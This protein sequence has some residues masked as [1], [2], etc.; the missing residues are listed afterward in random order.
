MLPTPS[1]SH[2]NTDQIYEPAEDSFLILDTLSSVGEI[3]FLSERFSDQHVTT[4][5]SPL[6]LEVGTGSGVVLAFL[7]AHAEAIFGRPDILTLGSDINHFACQ[8]SKRTVSQACVEAKTV[9]TKSQKRCYTGTMLATMSADLTGPFRAGVIDVLVFNPPYVPS[10]KVPLSWQQSD[11]IEV[12]NLPQKDHFERDSAL[13][14]L[15][16]EGGKNGMEVAN[17]LLEQLPRILCESKGMAYI[18]LCQ[19]NRPAEVVERIRAWGPRWSVEVVGRSD[20]RAG[21]EKLQI[22]RICR[23]PILC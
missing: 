5:A 11:D 12:Q 2:V 4:N 13:L 19:Q 16:Y 17:R 7:T 15:S 18:L 3:N 6:L 21:W 23:V 22:I 9:T 20:K 8:A 14:S 10:P 1:T